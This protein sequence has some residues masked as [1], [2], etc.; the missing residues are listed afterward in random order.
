[1]MR[2]L[3]LLALLAINFGASYA[4][5]YSFAVEKNGGGIPVL[6]LPGFTCPG[7][8]WNETVEHLG[9]RY[10]YHQISYAG[11]NGIEPIELPW[12]STILEDLKRYIESEKMGDLI[13]VGHS[14]GG[15]LAMDLAAE[16]PEKVTKLVLVDAL[17]C[18]RQLMMPHLKAED[19][20]LD[21]PYN[22]RMLNMDDEAFRQN[23]TYMAQNMTNSTD[24]TNDLI[25]WIMQADRKTYT[26]GYTELLKLDQREKIADIKARTLILAADFPHK[27]TVNKNLEQQFEKLSQKEIRIATSSKHFIMFDQKA[28]FFDQ[29]ESFL[30][31]TDRD[32]L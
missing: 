9:K 28:W 25:N 3:M 22:Q 12:Y 13:I 5:S 10:Q 2:K 21:N 16:M 20:T 31:S 27:E 11:F 23:A 26:Y 18:I 4:Q 7:E 8:I 1:M 24:K 14:M 15:M 17:P 19:I 29:L 6:L 30:L 32:K